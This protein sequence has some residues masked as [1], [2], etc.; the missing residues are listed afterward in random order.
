[1]SGLK[2]TLLSE[3]SPSVDVEEPQVDNLQVP[4]EQPVF[5][6]APSTNSHYIQPNP[7]YDHDRQPVQQYRNTEQHQDLPFI[8]SGEGY[9]NMSG[10]NNGGN[11]NGTWKVIDNLRNIETKELILLFALMYA[12]QQSSFLVWVA[13][14]LPMSV[15]EDDTMRVLLTTVG[16]VLCFYISKEYI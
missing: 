11:N 14:Y 13:N 6:Q 16:T 4:I 10:N 2:E 12:L 15:K 1:M 7:N 5:E 8:T 9:R 3:L